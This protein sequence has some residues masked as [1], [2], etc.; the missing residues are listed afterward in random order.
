MSGQQGLGFSVYGLGFG[1]GLAFRCCG[2][3]GV[4]A[5]G[6]RGKGL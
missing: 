5:E 2:I 1:V 6:A 4:Q 3:R